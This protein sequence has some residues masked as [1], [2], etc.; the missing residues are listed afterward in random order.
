MTRED[1]TYAW[2]VVAVLGLS[3]PRSRVEQRIRTPTPS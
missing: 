2:L 3:G 1:G